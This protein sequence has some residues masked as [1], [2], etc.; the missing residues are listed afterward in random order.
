M[1][2]ISKT[3]AL[4]LILVI[5]MSCLTLLTVKPASAQTVAKP[6]IPQFTLSF[7]YEWSSTGAYL[8]NAYITVRVRNQN[9]T[10]YLNASKYPIQLYYDVR[11]KYYL[12]SYWEGSLFSLG[13]FP[14]QDSGSGY[15]D[16]PIGFDVNT[17]LPPNDTLIS[18][19]FGLE[20]IQAEACIGYLNR[21]FSIPNAALGTYFVG[22]S[23]GWSNT[24]TINASIAPPP[25]PTQTTHIPEFPSSLIPLPLLLSM[26]VVA[27]IVRHRKPST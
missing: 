18:I 11:W 1:G 12:T 5:T 16:I 26:F 15:T 13:V 22:Q 25:T 17:S 8:A 24:Q 27:M 23:S 4:F 3:F 2:R 9:F 6:S 14:I 7:K 20:D 10:P 21:N 19:P